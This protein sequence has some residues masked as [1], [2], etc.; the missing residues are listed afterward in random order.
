M[1]DA[2]LNSSFVS[3]K[4]D[5][6]KRESIGDTSPQRLHFQVPCCTENQ[7]SMMTLPISVLRRATLQGAARE[8]FVREKSHDFASASRC[9]VDADAS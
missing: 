6:A 9:V 5:T 2:N 1:Q 7:V 4:R 8:S 3:F